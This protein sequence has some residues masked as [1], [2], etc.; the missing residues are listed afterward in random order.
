MIP[1]AGTVPDPPDGTHIVD[2]I[3]HIKALQNKREG[4]QNSIK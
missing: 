2:T 3:D 4:L 1:V